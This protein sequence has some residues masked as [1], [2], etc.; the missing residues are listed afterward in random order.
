MGHG[1]HLNFEVLAKVRFTVSSNFQTSLQN[2]KTTKTDYMPVF[3]CW[4]TAV[5]LDTLYRV[6]KEYGGP[7]RPSFCDVIG[8]TKLYRFLFV[9][10]GI[11]STFIKLCWTIKNN[12]HLTWWHKCYSAHIKITQNFVRTKNAENRSGTDKL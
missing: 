8:V 4:T 12:Q 2:I 1:N 7:A 3:Y 5:F 11:V 9:G 6:P 10:E